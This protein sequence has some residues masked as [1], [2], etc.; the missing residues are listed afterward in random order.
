MAHFSGPVPNTAA[1]Q[2]LQAVVVWEPGAAENPLRTIG[3]LTLI[4]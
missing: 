1:V 3:G 4:E 2:S